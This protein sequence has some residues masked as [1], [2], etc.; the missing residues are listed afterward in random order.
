MLALAAAA[1]AAVTI[2]GDDEAEAVQLEPIGTEGEDPFT[3]SVAPQPGGSLLAYAE[4]GAPDSD[5]GPDRAITDITDKRGPYISAD[6]SE[7]GLYGGTLN[8]T[9]C[10]P[11]Q[12]VDF[13]LSEP[14]KAEAW[15]EVLG[16]TADD[17]EDYVDELTPAVLGAD[18]R[19]INHGF[20]DGRAT[21]R[22][23]V[24]QRGS[25]V[26]VDDGGV[27][28]VRCF[29]GNPLLEPTVDADAGE[30]RYEGDEWPAFDAAQVVIV[31]ESS[32]RLAVV[33][34]VDVETGKLFDRPVGTTGEAD[35][36]PTADV[37]E[38]D[39]REDE[40]ELETGFVQ[41]TL[42]WSTE[43][44]VDLAV[45]DPLGETVS[46][47][48]QSVSSGGQLDVD[49]NPGCGSPTNVPVENIIWPE[50]APS[51]T[52]EVEVNLFADCDAGTSQDFVL[53]VTVGGGSVS[54]PG[55]G[56]G[57]VTDGNPVTYTFEVP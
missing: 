28:R 16:L 51:G 9:S 5:D 53:S 12:L 11:D 30:E 4:A 45:T 32:A 23:A 37:G 42:R 15:A 22:E 33:K 40:E 44:D 29:C 25:A 27:P 52:Y 19:V 47:G 24:L 54:L 55:G 41:V 49:A 2:L 17:I 57:T 20:A 3:S 35:F 10:D 56:R 8:D 1:F 13:L 34:L 14:E 31:Q 50:G 46:F 36:D 26:L 48:N 43:A 6:G 18:T 7:P 38:M 21:P 39:E